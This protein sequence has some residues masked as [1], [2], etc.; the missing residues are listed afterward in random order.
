MKIKITS[1]GAH[2]EKDKI[3]C[4]AAIWTFPISGPTWHFF[5]DGG[6]GFYSISGDQCSIYDGKLDDY[7]AVKNEGQSSK[8]SIVHKALYGDEDMY[9]KM[10]DFDLKACQEFRELVEGTGDKNGVA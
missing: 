10:L 2:I 1:E 9:E 7:I 3:C 6:D 8:I 4:V 5:A